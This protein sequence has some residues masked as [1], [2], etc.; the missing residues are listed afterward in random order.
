MNEGL[1]GQLLIA[2]PGLDDPNF[3]RS[4]VLMCAHSDDGAMGLIINRPTPELS[5]GSLL[6]Q[7]DI[8][9]GNEASHMPIHFGGP[10]EHSRGFVLHSPDYTLSGA[11]L[12]VLDRFGMT[13]TIEV[14]RDIAAG[15]GP[16]ERLLAL[17]YSGWRAGQ[18]EEEL[19]QNGWLVGEATH[20]LV[21][22][23]PDDRKWEAAVES[24]GVDPA[25]LSPAGGTA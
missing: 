23:T 6:T 13:A 7:L 18:L 8:E 21:F 10:V 20:D 9:V 24:L 22:A 25:M 11:T 15:G 14:L 12:P 2:M 5:L 4:V 19:Q 3:Q 17:G 1:S 16:S